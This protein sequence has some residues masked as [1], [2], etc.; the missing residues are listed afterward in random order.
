MW[1]NEEG[2]GKNIWANE[3]GTLMVEAAI[4]FPII[5]IVVLIFITLSIVIHDTYVSRLA[6]SVLDSDSIQA[7]I[8]DEIE[9]NV[10]HATNIRKVTLNTDEKNNIFS[11]EKKAWVMDYDFPF[12]GK[13]EYESSNIEKSHDLKHK[14]MIIELAGDIFDEL[15][16]SQAGKDKF[17]LLLKSILTS[18]EYD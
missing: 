18:L 2:K 17:D 3:E 11:K 8:I 12:V 5:L 14:I 13:I 10:I 15:T 6:L 4:I 1:A 16:M 9:T 7:N